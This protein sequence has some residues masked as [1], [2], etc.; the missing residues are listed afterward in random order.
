V[1][2]LGCPNCREFILEHTAM[3]MLPS[4]FR[5]VKRTGVSSS[6]IA[7][8]LSESLAG[9]CL[10]KLSD[11]LQYFGVLLLVPAISFAVRE[12]SAPLVQMQQRAANFEQFQFLSSNCSAAKRVWI[13]DAEL[14]TLP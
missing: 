7:Q 11:L 13:D 8:V 5:K 10:P 4:E 12:K 9:E 14:C 6:K 2:L 3:C 1:L